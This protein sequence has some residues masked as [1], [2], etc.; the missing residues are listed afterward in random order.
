MFYS[1]PMKIKTS[2]VVESIGGE[3]KCETLLKCE[4]AVT[5]NAQSVLRRYDTNGRY[6]IQGGKNW[7]L[8]KEIK[9]KPVLV[10]L[11]WL[12]I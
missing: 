3:I 9:A 10:R 8:P 6:Q 11:H 5:T 7:I 4:C 2:S 1:S 12:E